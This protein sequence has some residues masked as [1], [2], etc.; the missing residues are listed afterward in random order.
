VNVAQ[1]LDPITKELDAAAAL[2]TGPTPPSPA[3]QASCGQLTE[4]VR[5]VESAQAR[6]V[7]LV[8]DDATLTKHL[9]LHREHVSG[10]AK[11]AKKAQIACLARDGNAMT[12]GM[13]E[14]R[15]QHSELAPSSAEITTY[16]N[17][18]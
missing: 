18:P 5:R 2:T 4:Q 7:L 3:D 8:S 11:A 6:L 14:S 9:E 10:W 16:C 12:E 15:R 1:A 13:S 17:A